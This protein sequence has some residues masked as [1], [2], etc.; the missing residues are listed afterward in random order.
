M[1]GEEGMALE[2]K[3]THREDELLEIQTPQLDD[4]SHLHLDAGRGLDDL[5]HLGP[6]RVSAKRNAGIAT[7]EVERERGRHR[8]RK[9]GSGDGPTEHGD[10]GGRDELSHPPHEAL[11]LPILPRGLRLPPP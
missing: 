5:T 8:I 1:S 4:I 10:V 9:A 2:E 7:T 6:R 11:R 3:S